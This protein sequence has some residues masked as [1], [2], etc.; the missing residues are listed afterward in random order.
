MKQI[1]THIKSNGK[2]DIK[3]ELLKEL[4]DKKIK[5][6]YEPEAEKKEKDA[7]DFIELLHNGPKAE[8]YRQKVTRA[9]IHER[10]DDGLLYR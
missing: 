2:L 9:W 1:I 3:L 6:I 10:E 8:G 7:K 4:I 5:I